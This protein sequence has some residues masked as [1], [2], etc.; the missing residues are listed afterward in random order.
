MSDSPDVVEQLR[1]FVA[2]PETPGFPPR[3][4]ALSQAEAASLLAVLDASER[5]KTKARQAASS[6]LRAWADT[7]TAL[8]PPSLLRAAAK[9]R[10]E[11]AWL[12]SWA[13]EI[14]RALA[15]EPLKDGGE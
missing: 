1:H 2:L 11:L 8:P 5:S 14:E 13:D 9:G 10:P 12:L 3:M 4:H 7:R 15:I 6:L